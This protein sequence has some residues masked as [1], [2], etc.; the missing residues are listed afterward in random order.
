MLLV[1]TLKGYV[2]AISPRHATFKGA[3]LSLNPS[4]RSWIKGL[5][6]TKGMPHMILPTWYLELVLAALNE[7]PFIPIGTCRLKY[8]IGKTVFLLAITSGCRAFEMH[9]LCCKPAYIRF[10]SAGVTL[11]TNLEFLLKVYTKANATWPIYVPV[12]HNPTDGALRKLC[13]CRALGEY[14]R[15]SSSYRQDSTAQLFVTHGGQVKGRSISQ[16]GWSST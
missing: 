12:M 16:T 2:T 10:S 7:A 14:V 13:V 6:H 4:I 11:F 1:N 8:L 15:C 9:A 5:E 3:S